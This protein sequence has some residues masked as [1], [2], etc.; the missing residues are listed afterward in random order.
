MGAGGST[1]QARGAQGGN[2][3]NFQRLQEVGEVYGGNAMAE[4]EAM[5]AE[6]Q[7]SEGGGGRGRLAPNPA[8]AAAAQG[9]QAPMSQMESDAA[10][11]RMLMEQ[12][13]AG[14]SQ[15][16]GV[17]GRIPLAPVAAPNAKA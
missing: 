13:A 16:R 12:D 10:L 2:P 15:Y 17:H 14:P 4:Y 11:A 7:A 9:G 1:A 3:A 6:A 5:A 8:S